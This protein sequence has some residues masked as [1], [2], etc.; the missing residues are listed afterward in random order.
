MKSLTL[1]RRG[2]RGGVMRPSLALAAVALLLGAC[3]SLEPGP[4]R[5]ASSSIADPESTPL[6][7]AFARDL[8]LHRAQSGFQVLATGH[9]ALVARGALAERVQRTLDLQ[10]Y[11]VGED[12]STEQLLER[13]VAAAERGVR[14]RVLLDDLFTSARSFG[15]RAAGAHPNIEVRLFN[16]F[17]AKLNS[18]PAR[19]PEMALDAARLNVRMHNKAWIAD[20]TAAVFGSRNMGDEYFDLSEAEGFTDIDLL[21]V[22][23]AVRAMSQAFDRYWNSD[24]AIPV[25]R[26]ASMPQPADHDRQRREWHA[27]AGDCQASTPCRWLAETDFREALR[28]GRLP[29][30]WAPARFLAD[31]PDGE[32][33]GV[34][35]GIEHGYLGDD[36]GGARTE[37]ELLIVSPY[38]IPDAH[39]IAHLSQMSQRGVRIAVLTNSLASTDSVAA[40]AGYAGRRLELLRAGV[41]LYEF[42]P[43]NALQHRMRHRWGHA[44]PASLHTKLVVQDR[45]RVLLGSL[46]QDPRSRLHNTESWLLI[47]SRALAAELAAHVEEGTELHHSFRVELAPDATGSDALAWLSSE[48]GAFVRHE[49]EPMT[50]AW[51]RVWRSVLGALIPEHLL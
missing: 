3:A 5:P 42:K 1:L 47:E 7:R 22:G 15:V 40:H 39:G 29:L 31:S 48:Q 8:E 9:E 36:P 41:E 35:S 26:L 44:S 28:E 24:R 25:E 13:L 32:K 30:T 50:D 11:S 20:N 2:A 14:V 6:G 33:R 21:V 43:Q 17:R 46:N 10:Y 34:P 4:P 18:G 16:P 19:V 49:T 37:S 12:S 27:Q 38:F 45:A 51:L 23:P